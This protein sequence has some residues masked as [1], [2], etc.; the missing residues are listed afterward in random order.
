MKK[1]R[2]VGSGLVG[3]SIGLALAGHN[4]GVEM[5]D[6]DAPRAALAQKLVGIAPPGKA[7]LTILAIPTSSL[8][9]VIDNEFQLNPKSTFI[10]IASTKT[11]SNLL[12]ATVAGLSQRFCGTHPMA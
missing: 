11:K 9:Q 8:E 5:A 4:H 2:I 6:I 12:V 7:E 1:V 3:T 10:D